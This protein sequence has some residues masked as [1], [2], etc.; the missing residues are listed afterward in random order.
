MHA[1][2]PTSAGRNCSQSGVVDSDLVRSD[3]EKELN[4]P[5]KKQCLF[6]GRGPFVPEPKLKNDE[7]RSWSHDSEHHDLARRSSRI[8]PGIYVDPLERTAAQTGQWQ[9]AI[10]FESRFQSNS[11]FLGASKF[12][13]PRIGFNAIE[14]SRVSKVAES[15]E[16][17]PLEVRAGPLDPFVSST[18]GRRR[19]TVSVEKCCFLYRSPLTHAKR[20]WEP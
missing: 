1:N 13:S 20:A 4:A 14:V 11:A 7:R 12:G 6:P 10:A 2:D 5:E 15:E 17:R 9:R 18:P 3:P 16:S 19:A 8:E